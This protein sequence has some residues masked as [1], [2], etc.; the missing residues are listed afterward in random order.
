MRSIVEAISPSAGSVARNP[1]L[2]R[3]DLPNRAVDRLDVVQR[4]F[5]AQGYQGQ[6][7]FDDAMLQEGETQIHRS[8]QLHPPRENA[9]AA[10]ADGSTLKGRKFYMH[11]KPARGDL[12]LEVCPVG[13][14]FA[15][16]LHFQ[17]LAPGELGLLLFGLG[18]GSTH[19]CPKLGGAKPA[20]L[21]TIEVTEPHVRMSTPAERYSDFDDEAPADAAIEPF[22]AEARARGLVLGE[23]LDA[24]AAILRW[25]NDDRNCPDRS[26]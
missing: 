24:I 16:T 17:N 26:Y 19:F 7:S 25:P 9:Q 12:P 5:G 11:G 20:C 3:E 8:V 15:L 21:G 13:S 23:Q 18:L 4:L 2:P 22:L 6:I 1:D 10:Y 14:R